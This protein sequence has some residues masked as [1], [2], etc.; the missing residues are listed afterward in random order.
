MDGLDDAHDRLDR[1]I[2]NLCDLNPNINAQIGASARKEIE[3]LDNLRNAGRSGDADGLGRAA[4]SLIKE[5]KTLTGLC[6]GQAGKT[7]DPLRKKQIT[8]A[9]DELQRLLPHELLA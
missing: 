1:A 9:V 7:I 3:D 8:D 4:K 6:A 5:N 2:Q